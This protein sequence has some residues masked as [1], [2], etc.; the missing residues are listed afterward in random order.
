MLEAL[1]AVGTGVED[2]L[3]A[4]E[5]T[6]VLEPTQR[7]VGSVDKES[8]II[9][10]ADVLLRDLLQNPEAMLAWFSRGSGER[11]TYISYP[12]FRASKTGLRVGTGSSSVKNNSIFTDP[13]RLP[14]QPN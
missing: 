13:M 10:E 9:C 5:S 7:S 4:V 8:F 14:Y 2:V 6:G 1:E 12:L 3:Q 11:G